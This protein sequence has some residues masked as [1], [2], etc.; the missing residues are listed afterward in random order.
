[1]KA[2]ETTKAACATHFMIIGAEDASRSSAI[3]TPGSATTTVT[4]S[5]AYTDFS[6]ATVSEIIKPYI[7][8]CCELSSRGARASG[9]FHRG[10][11]HSVHWLAREARLTAHRPGVA[12]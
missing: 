6:P 8:S 5:V 4:G 11:D 12:F 10:R 9:R 7:Y 3:V 2:A 1:M